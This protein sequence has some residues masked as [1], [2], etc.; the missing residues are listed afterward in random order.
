MKNNP[1]EK[2]GIDDCLTDSDVQATC[3]RFYASVYML[4]DGFY[5]ESVVSVSNRDPSFITPQIKYML[6]QKNQLMRK[7]K[8]EAANALA[9]RIKSKIV[10]SNSTNF[11][12]INNVKDLWEK[13]R[14][15]S[16]KVKS[17][18]VVGPGITAETLN[19]HYA[20]IS[21]DPEYVAPVPK[22]TAAFP[23][24]YFSEIEIFHLLDTLK[25]TSAGA[26]SIPAWFLRISAPII[27]KPVATLYNLSVT[28][29]VVPKQWKVGV[30]T[31]VAKVARPSVCS[32]FRPITVTPI[33]SRLLEKL[34]VRK[35]LYPIFSDSAFS[36]HFKDQFAFRPSGSTTSALVNLTHIL[37]DLLQSHPYVHLIALDFSKAFDTVRHFTLLDKCRAFPIPDALFNWILRFLEGRSHKTKFGGLLS[38]LREITASIVQG[39]GIGP[40]AFVIHVSDLHPLC[41]LIFLNKYADDCYLIAPSDQAA[42]IPAELAHIEAWAKENNLKLNILKTKEM[43]VHRPRVKVHDLPSTVPGMERVSSMKILGVV[44]EGDLS[45]RAQVDR[46][47]GQSNQSVCY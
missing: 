19:N 43:I 34:V 37:S 2:F 28:W 6:R 29:A 16:G 11:R 27:Y 42:L 46:L 1:D 8:I 39:S 41:L 32:D 26:D 31:P 7:G 24:R 13:V 17:A 22:S 47:V 4:L 23:F 25:P 3:D 38:R 45:F 44:F 14:Q 10:S 40:A 30:I 9:G 36:R 12:S 33:L 21:T 20:D 35:F 5:P 18:P 15:C